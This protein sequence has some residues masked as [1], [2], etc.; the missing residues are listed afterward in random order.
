MTV[1]SERMCV[2]VC[3]YI[4]TINKSLRGCVGGCMYQVSMCVFV[5]VIRGHG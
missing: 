3:T 1:G 4:H 5:S 2:C